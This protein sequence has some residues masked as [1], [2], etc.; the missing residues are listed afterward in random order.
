MLQKFCKSGDFNRVKQIWV[1][2]FSKEQT[3]PCQGSERNAMTQKKDNA[4]EQNWREVLGS[5]PD[6]LRALVQQVV[7][8]VLE[9]E[10]EETLRAEKGERTAERLGYRAGYYTRRLV[11]RV[12]KLVLRVPQ[13]RQGR[14]RTGVFERY[15]RSEKAPVSALTEMYGAAV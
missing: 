14:F 7:Q 6:G 12:G 1:M 10:M 4:K 11:T 9:A 15:Q 8:E 5:G 3:S 2:M 13:D